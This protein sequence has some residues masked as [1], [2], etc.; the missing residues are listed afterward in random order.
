MDEDQYLFGNQDDL[1]GHILE[2]EVIS[3]QPS[4]FETIQQLFTK[5]K[6]LVMQC[7]QC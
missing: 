5:F 4:T 3:L 2:N 6:S 1:R 7:K